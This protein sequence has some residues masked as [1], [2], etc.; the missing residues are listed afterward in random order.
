MAI[1]RDKFVKGD[2]NIRALPAEGRRKHPIYQFLSMNKH[3]AFTVK[4]IMKAVS[5]NE[6]TVRGMLT[7]MKRDKLIEHKSPYYTVK[8]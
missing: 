7:Q 3:S 1:S 5:K 4:E 6:N 2:F 8:K